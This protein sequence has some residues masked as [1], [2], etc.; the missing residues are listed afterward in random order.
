[1]SQKVRPE[2]RKP[3]KR[4]T[5]A[6]KTLA[7]AATLIML[8]GMAGCACK[9]EDQAPVST[10]TKAP[11]TTED[12]GADGM[13]LDLAPLHPVRNEPQGAADRPALDA[14][15]SARGSD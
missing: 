10:K 3:V 2:E 14:D 5:G 4:I 15:A 7:F 6:K 11:S 12:A 13:A 1:M 8:E 9:T